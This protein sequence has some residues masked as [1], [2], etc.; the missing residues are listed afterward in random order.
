[1]PTRF[2]AY[3][4]AARSRNAAVE[5]RVANDEPTVVT[6]RAWLAA[7]A[8]CLCK[9]AKRSARVGAPSLTGS[10]GRGDAAAAGGLG[11]KSDRKSV[12]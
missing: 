10:D 4:H 7:A 2:R 6:S 1:M 8:V 9:R 3:V 12:V 5:L 11:S